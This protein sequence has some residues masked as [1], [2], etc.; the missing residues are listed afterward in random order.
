MEKLKIA[1]VARFGNQ[2]GVEYHRL[3]VPH[4]NLS[5]EKYDITQTNGLGT[6]HP[7]SISD[8]QIV[9]TNRHLGSNPEQTKRLADK[10]GTKLIL[11]LD[12]YWVLPPHHGLSKAYKDY[13]TSKYTVECIK[14]AHHVTTTH[15]YFANIIRRH[16]P[17][18]TVIP[19]AIDPKQPQNAPVQQIEK[20]R[21]N[22]GWVGGI[23][24][25]K[26][27]LLLKDSIKDTYADKDLAGKFRFL[28]GG[29]NSQ[30]EHF[31]RIFTDNYCDQSLT[32]YGRINALPVDQ[33]MSMY[34]FLD[35]C[36]A[37][38]V[39]DEFNRCK[40]QLKLIEAG[41]KKKAVIASGVAPY[42]IDGVHGKNVLLVPPHAEQKFRKHIK[43]VIQSEQLRVDLAESLHEVVMSKYLIHHSNA[44]REELYNRLAGL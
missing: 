5:G 31:E 36:L 2:D 13:N 44:I 23:H 12:D 40:S 6:E 17:N 8:Y 21:V 15:E 42:L 32:H 41:Y 26:D 25:H 3:F 11:D 18:V 33:Y 27:L 30:Y 9:V 4:V 10:H 43:R 34:E 24:H 35:V 29:W 19:N 38:L 28:L 20:D 39:D 16:N 37:P 1:F 7:E 14:A 22:I